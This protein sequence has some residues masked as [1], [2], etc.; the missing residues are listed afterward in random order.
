[1]QSPPNLRF[2][3]GIKKLAYN[4]NMSW[5]KIHLRQLHELLHKLTF[6]KTLLLDTLKK[7]KIE[8]Y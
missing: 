2:F 4:M 7:T 8:A 3:M 6:P 1:M 5:K